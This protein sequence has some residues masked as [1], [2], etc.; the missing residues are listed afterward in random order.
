MQ[1]EI[2]RCL[3]DNELKEFKENVE[4]AEEVGYD[5]NTQYGKEVNEYCRASS[6]YLR[7]RVATYYKLPF[8]ATLS[9]TGLP[10]I[11]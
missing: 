5:L 3:E 11:W 6:S 10:I 7:L 1:S 8:L 9:C 2:A 4:A